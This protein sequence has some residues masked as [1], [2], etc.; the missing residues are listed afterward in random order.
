MTEGEANATAGAQQEA[1][2]L[3]SAMLVVE[4]SEES[5]A[6]KNSEAA[7]DLFG[8]TESLRP[9]SQTQMEFSSPVIQPKT[10]EGA[11]QQP[12]QI[13]REEPMML[14]LDAVREKDVSIMEVDWDHLQSPETIDI[15]ELDSM[16]DAY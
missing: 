13:K 2:S 4:E 7:A 11:A 5:L 10:E 9:W 1:S 6:R 8:S 12:Q 14:D 16:F 3:S 15:A